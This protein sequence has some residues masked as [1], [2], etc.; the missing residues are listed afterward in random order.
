MLEEKKKSDGFRD[1]R[2]EGEK[3]LDRKEA[4]LGGHEGLSKTME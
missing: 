2:L 4:I 1:E 3:L